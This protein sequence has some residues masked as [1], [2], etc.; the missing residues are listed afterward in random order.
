MGS[1]FDDYTRLSQSGLFDA[2]Y[3]LAAYPEVATRNIDPLLHYVE[4]GAREGRNPRPDFDHQFYV[5]QCRALGDIP[6]NPLVH[7]V[8]VGKRLGLRT[9]AERA[10]GDALIHI[11]EATLSAE[12]VFQIS[13]WTVAVAPIIEISIFVGDRLLGQATYG[14]RRDDVAAV[15][16]AMPN[17]LFSGFRMMEP[18]DSAG[19]SGATV[20][21]VAMTDSG[22]RMDAA[23]P[24]TIAEDLPSSSVEVAEELKLF[25]DAPRSVDGVVKD[26]VRSSLPVSGWALA[27]HGITDIE[28]AVDGSNV[29][30]TRCTVR[31]P[32]VAKAFP[33]WPNAANS[34]F[35]TV[36]PRKAMPVGERSISVTVRDG[37]G[38]SATANFSV[39]VEE[40]NTGE[41]PWAIR[42]KMRQAEIDLG[43]GMLEELSWRP[44]FRWLLICRDEGECDRIRS[45]FESL[46]L[47]AYGDWCLTIVW[48][49][50]RRD[51]ARFKA[52]LLAG[53]DDI[54]GKIICM[55]ASEA[56]DATKVLRAGEHHL[57]GML[58]AGDKLGIDALLE[59]AIVSGIERKADFFYSDEERPSPT[60][61]T[62][63]AFFKPEWS[64]DLM[65]ATNYIGRLWCARARLVEQIGATVS[66][67]L[68]YGEYDLVLRATEAAVA[69]RHVPKV[70]C[71]QAGPHAGANEKDCQALERAMER[72][73]INGTIETGRAPGI[74]RVRRELVSE[75]LVSII[76]PTCAA[77]GLIR[78][79]I[80]SIRAITNYRN[81]EI[82]CIENIP[83][84][85]RDWKSWLRRSAD[86]VVSI[87]EPFNWSRF[88]N[89]AVAKSS[90]EYLLFLNDDIEVTEAQ[91]LEA[92]LA[93]VQRPEVGAVGGLLLYPDGSVQ[94]AGMFLASLGKARHA[95][96]HAQ[97]DDPGYF[98][99]MLTQRNV[100]AVTGACLMT[101]RETFDALGG[102]DERHDVINNDV[103]FCLRAW[104]S[105][106]LNVV[107]PSVKL[108]HYEQASR[109][110]IA[111]SFDGIE[112]AKKWS[113]VFLRGDPYFNP[114]FS[115]ETDEMAIA[116]EPVVVT[117]SGRPL[118]DRKSIK[119]ILLVKLDHIG[120]AILALP[121]V[122]HLKKHLP[123]ASLYVLGGSWT[124]SIWTKEP[125]ID[126]FIPFDF[127]HPRSALGQKETSEEALKE[128][129]RKLSSYRFDLAIDLRKQPDTRPVLLHVGARYLAGYDSQGRFPWLDIAL[130]WEGDVGFAAKRTHNSDDL[131]VL[132]DAIAVQSDA[133]RSTLDVSRI[134]PMPL[135]S[136]SLT[137]LFAKRVVCV[138][139]TAGNAMKEWPLD[140]YAALIDLLVDAED[141]NVA[142]IGSREERDIIASVKAAVRRNKRVWDLCGYLP[143]EDLPG[144]LTRCALFIGNDSG[145]KH[146]AA[147]L[148]VR[149][150]GIHSG[151]VDISEWGPIGTEAV[152]VSRQVACSPCY[153]STP[154][155]CSRDL[156][157][158]R[159]IE[160]GDVDRIARRLLGGSATGIEDT[161]QRRRRRSGYGPEMMTEL[162]NLGAV[163]PEGRPLEGGRPMTGTAPN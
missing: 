134:E 139:A 160:C 76:I 54:A 99:L 45:T 142:L 74:Y 79:C 81:F 37:R 71:R 72:R 20:T 64:P 28:I 129:G 116:N 35:G 93:E 15:H 144:F 17:A 50:R 113:D 39:T 12:R 32:D 65:L 106:L 34:G 62:V 77:R 131:T 147:G 97:Q 41:G 59:L 121:A 156:A 40:A 86:K 104:A 110:E 163:Q 4:H 159:G 55:P 154:S 6:E 8:T 10:A 33:D 95:F 85:D 87:S 52:R 19:L 11:D 124:R 96:R 111:E 88:N 42:K 30:N 148:G 112:F 133:N 73:G 108:T 47:Q 31:R 153:L 157:C 143:L 149:T 145:P 13:G 94:H 126:E 120:D 60:T 146:I 84:K 105:G 56:E 115:R 80:E 101:R 23:M 117:C 29:A 2:G 127:F 5:Q 1:L 102:F 66:D 3:Y 103:D 118:Y 26:V 25:I 114:N 91:W 38:R 135:R 18:L 67:L 24:L 61:G 132:V 119:R 46:R 128:L 43:V 57:F 9:K 89:L 155:E 36:I 49:G 141:V 68:S 78:I 75:G 151:V 48:A 21:A 122:R 70:L 83:K 51:I 63:G 109:G 82:V 7:Y 69:I 130:E 44:E 107:V 100:M 138:H 90:G 140:R 16:H 152:A 150:I 123:D 161:Q 137:R 22:L 14:E 136:P 158:I 125:L 98:G 162:R 92:L 27:R 58:A 53:F